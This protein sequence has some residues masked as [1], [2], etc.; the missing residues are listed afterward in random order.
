VEP[1]SERTVQN[2]D[3]WVVRGR[4]TSLCPGVAMA[5]G[6]GFSVA[7]NV[8][9]SVTRPGVQAADGW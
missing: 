1:D 9:T 2:A 4:W 5:A 3:T 8:A 6:K 7:P